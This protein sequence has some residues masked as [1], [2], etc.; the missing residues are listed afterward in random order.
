MEIDYEEL[1]RIVNKTPEEDQRLYAIPA[2]GIFKA[3]I[4]MGIG[5]V[6]E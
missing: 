3:P 4:L 2:D 6:E 1:D 5:R